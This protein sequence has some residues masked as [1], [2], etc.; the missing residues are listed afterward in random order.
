M[1][2]AL[3]GLAAL[4]TLSALSVAQPAVAAGGDF[5]TAGGQVQRRF[6]AFG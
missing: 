4:T 6:V 3:A 2:K 5:T 1:S